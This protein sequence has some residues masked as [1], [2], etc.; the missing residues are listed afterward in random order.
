M[1]AA[2]QYKQ[3]WEEANWIRLLFLANR[4]YEALNQIFKYILIGANVFLF[5]IYQAFK[6]FWLI[7]KLLLLTEP[8][9]IRI[10]KDETWIFR[11]IK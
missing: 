8:S 5:I 11:Q 4:I 6:A 7:L 2:K 9:L 1:K 10:E 3:Q